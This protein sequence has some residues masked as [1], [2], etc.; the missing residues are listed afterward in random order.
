V[1]DSQSGILVMGEEV[2][3]GKVAVSYESVDVSVGTGA[4]F[5][6]A[7]DEEPTSF[8]IEE[9]TSVEDFVSTLRAVGLETKVVIEILKALDRAGALYGT[10]IVM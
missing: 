4:S 3:I 6:S 10:L 8:V 1:I 7:L 9:T 5:Y 2:R